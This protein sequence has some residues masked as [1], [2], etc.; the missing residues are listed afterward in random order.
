M[1]EC[2]ETDCDNISDGD[3]LFK[4]DYFD[5]CDIDSLVLH[6][7]NEEVFSTHFSHFDHH[8]TAPF[9]DQHCQGCICQDVIFPSSPNQE[10]VLEKTGE[11]I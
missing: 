4:D 9:N 1:V 5:D 10:I 8:L 7:A 3:F 11:K 6:Y 2:L